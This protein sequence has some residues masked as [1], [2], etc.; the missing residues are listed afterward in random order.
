MGNCPLF[1]TMIS[2][3]N[4]IKDQKD[5]N[6]AWVFEFYLDLPERLFGQ[7]LQV[8]SIFNPTERTPSMF[9]YY[10]KT[11]GDYRFK[12]FSS[13][14]QGSA[15]DLV[16]EIFKLNFSQALFRIIEDYNKYIL[17][18]GEHDR[19]ECTPAAKYKV[20][21]IKKRGWYKE[22]V[23]FWLSFNIGASI[24]EEFN[25][26]P[27][28][29]YNMIKEDNNS[30]DKITIRNKQ[31]YGYFDKNGLIYKIYQP[32]QKNYKFIKVRPYTQGLDQLVYKKPNLII[33]SSL[34]DAMCLRQF[35]F[36]V[37]VIAPDS[38]NTM[39]KPY[40]INNLKNKFKKIITLFDN[41]QAGHTAINKY[42]LHYNIHGT[43]LELEKDLSDAVKKHGINK[44]KKT[45]A[46]LLSKTIKK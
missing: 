32:S 42:L 25:V 37:E 43:Y 39:I 30:F 28:E 10:G 11:T 14:S 15:I 9:I 16:Q 7:D 34:K 24:L 4:F 26:Y 6:T 40:V 35:N 21:F 31:M 22:D 13:G 33:C 18:H 36:N 12:D 8:K 3:K 29:Y 38:E 23:N 44:I 20:D 17:K 5:V 41:D 45:I 19:I 27:I 2:T 1:L 46:P